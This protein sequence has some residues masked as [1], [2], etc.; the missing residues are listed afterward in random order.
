MTTGGLEIK[1]IFGWSLSGARHTSHW[2]RCYLHLRCPM[3]LMTE[4]L[5][6]DGD[7]ASGHDDRALTNLRIFR[8][9][10]GSTVLAISRCIVG[11]WQIQN[12]IVMLSSWCWYPNDKHGSTSII[13]KCPLFKRVTGLFLVICPLQHSIISSYSL[14]VLTFRN[15]SK[16]ETFT[17]SQLQSSIPHTI[18]MHISSIHWNS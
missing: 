2:M 7:G 5:S 15:S 6:Q 10:D 4:L 11:D 13:Y 17:N 12:S 9:N 3:C 1:A 18:W 16:P 14:S 8:G